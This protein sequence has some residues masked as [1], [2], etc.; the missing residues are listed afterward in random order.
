M[1]TFKTADDITTYHKNSMRMTNCIEL[2]WEHYSMESD[3][4]DIDQDCLEYFLRADING[5][6]KTFEQLYEHINKKE[7]K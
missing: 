1:T 3:M 4:E 6:H 7:I 5:E 2:L